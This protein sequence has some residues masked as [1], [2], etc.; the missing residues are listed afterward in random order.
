MIHL[1]SLRPEV[2]EF[3]GNAGDLQAYQTTCRKTSSTARAREVALVSH[4][5]EQAVALLRFL[6]TGHGQSQSQRSKIGHCV[7][8]R[9]YDDTNIVTTPA[10]GDGNCAEP[11]K[12][13]KVSQLLAMIQHVLIRRTDKYDDQ[14]AL[15]TE[16]AEIHCP[17][18]IIPKVPRFSVSVL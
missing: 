18:Q 16:I 7:M 10:A 4:L 6:G 14:D 11:A 15:A 9:Q 17:A 13:K 3:L 2:A 8:I 12:R 5:R 1:D